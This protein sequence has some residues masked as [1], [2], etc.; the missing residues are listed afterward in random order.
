MVMPLF[1]H[2]AVPAKKRR[3][4]VADLSVAT[5]HLGL[6]IDPLGSW[7]SAMKKVYSIGSARLGINETVNGVI[8]INV[9]VGVHGE[10]SSAMLSSENVMSTGAIGMV[11]ISRLTGVS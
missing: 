7:D 4:Y 6:G 1:L 5:Q 9:P 11:T 8:H 3:D 2:L 10:A